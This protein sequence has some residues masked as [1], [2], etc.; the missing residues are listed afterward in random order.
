MAVSSQSSAHEANELSSDRR[1]GARFFGP[2]LDVSY[3]EETAIPAI[4]D[5]KKPGDQVRLWAMGCGGGEA[6]YSLAMLVAEASRL[7]GLV[8][9]IAVFATDMDAGQLATARGGR[10]DEAIA[11]DVSP[12][13]LEQWFMPGHR[14]FIVNKELRSNCSFSL[15]DLTRDVPFSHLDLIYCGNA[16]QS[17]SS[18]LQDHAIPLLHFALSPGGYLLPCTDECMARTKLF[19]LAQG[20]KGAYCREDGNRQVLPA[21]PLTPDAKRITDEYYMAAPAKAANAPDNDVH[22]LQTELTW[23]KEQLRTTNQQLRAANRRLQFSNEEYQS[24]NEELKSTNEE[25]LSSKAELQSVNRELW[26]VNSELFHRIDQLRKTNC[27][28]RNFMD[29][30]RISTLFL[31]RK[32]QIMRFTPAIAD[33]FHVIESDIGRAITDIAC[34]LSYGLLADDVAHVV[35]TLTPIERKLSNPQ[36]G[37]HYLLRILPYRNPDDV[38]GGAVLTFLDISM[39]AK[40]EEVARQSEARLRDVARSV[41]AALFTAGADMA[42]TYVNPRFYEFTGLPDGTALGSGWLAAVHPADREEIEQRLARARLY[43]SGVEHEFRLRDL[44]G[45]YR[46]YLLRA[47]ANSGTD[48]L[49]GWTGSL[50]DIHDRRAAEAQQ[51]LLFVELQRRVKTILGTV[52]S[53]AGHTKGS[54]ASLDDFVAHFDGRLAAIARA[55]TSIARDADL[56]VDLEELVSEEILSHAVGCDERVLLSGP[57]LRIGDRVSQALGLAIHEL[58]TNALKYGALSKAVGS[59]DVSW[60]L[61]QGEGRQLVHLEWKEHAVPVIDPK[62]R[63]IGFGRDFLERQLTA[64]LEAKTSLEFRA[65]GIHFTIDFP[66]QDSRSGGDES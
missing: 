65:G 57:T 54:S 38:V 28:L 51:R 63:R 23:T 53:V 66:L 50:L 16:L 41:P 12:G 58:T 5:K 1:I 21:F 47:I 40:A 18:E 35:H 44:D 45:G 42:W 11:A 32:L 22:W 27:D 62:P 24:L 59:V 31:D 2:E 3:L 60:Q 36:T 10:F 19:S 61:L 26:A 30:T 9:P 8:L 49:T 33:I 55:Q 52:R 13:R 56:G 34:E 20:A 4:L 48:D 29:S 43:N 6:A 46:W 15:H 25:L 64:E 39:M 37:A 17:L 7:S 14:G